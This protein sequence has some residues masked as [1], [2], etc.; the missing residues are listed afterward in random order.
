MSLFF[1]IATLS[2]ITEIQEYEKKKLH[3]TVSDEME[4]EIQSWQARWRRESLEHYLPNGWCFLVKNPALK[5]EISTEGQLVG[6][7]LAQPL[8]FFDGQTQSLWVEH[9]ASSSL[10][11]R[12]ELCDLAYRLSREKHFQRVYFPNNPST[13]NAIRNLKPQPW[14]DSAVFVKTTKA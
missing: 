8:L 6:Y 1:R 4:R 11:A 10:Q 5:S 3:D 13:Q 12:D 14:S 7:F 9:I 2:D